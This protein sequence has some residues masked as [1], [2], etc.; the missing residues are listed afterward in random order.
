V[1]LSGSGEVY[2]QGFGDGAGG[3]GAGRAPRGGD[4]AARDADGADARA[5]W[6][7]S[8]AE[9]QAA[10]GG[11]LEPLDGKKRRREWRDL[12]PLREF[13]AGARGFDGLLRASCALEVGCPPPPPRR[14]QLVRNEGRD[15]SN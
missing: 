10:T 12:R 8:P 5:A 4:G 13:L 2:V 14:V 6:R 9:G 11:E 7:E 3:E 15:V 1:L